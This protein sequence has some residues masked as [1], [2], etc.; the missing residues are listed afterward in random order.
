MKVICVGGGLAGFTSSTH[1]ETPSNLQ[2]LLQPG[3]HVVLVCH[4]PP[5]VMLSGPEPQLAPELSNY[6]IQAVVLTHRAEATS[7]SELKDLKDDL[8]S[9]C[10][11]VLGLT[12]GW[13][14]IAAAT[15]SEIL[16]FAASNDRVPRNLEVQAL[17]GYDS[18]LTRLSMRVALEIALRELDSPLGLHVSGVTMTPAELLAPALEIARTEQSFSE[19]AAGLEN[20]VSSDPKT[21]RESVSEALDQLRY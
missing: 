2:Q 5:Y 8:G 9:Q 16:D 13:D 4:G 7:S 6:T 14:R 1:A 11:R 3:E 19:M 20:A 21:L 18:P 15:R 10:R 12:Q 17:L